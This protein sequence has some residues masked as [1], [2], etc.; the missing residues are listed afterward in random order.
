[1]GV[2][3]ASG[4]IVGESLFNVAL[5]GLIVATNKGEP[6][7]VVG[8]AFTQE[9]VIL[10]LIGTVVVVAALYGFSALVSQ[11]CGRRRSLIDA[12]ALKR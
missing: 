2:L 9:G 5:A 1:M 4:L 12:P 3:M 8:D 6:L 7:A 11:T 10:G